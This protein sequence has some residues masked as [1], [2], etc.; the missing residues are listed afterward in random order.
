MDLSNHV[1]KINGLIV[2][3]NRD[4]ELELEVRFKDKIN[5]SKFTELLGK[6]KGMKSHLESVDPIITE[7]LDI[8]FPEKGMN[9]R[10]TLT[11]NK[12]IISFCKNGDFKGIEPQFIDK[13]RVGSWI[14]INDYNIRFNLKKEVVKSQKSPEVVAIKSQINNMNKEFRYKKRYSFVTKD[15]LFQFDLTVLKTSTTRE[16][17]GANVKKMKKEVKPFMEKFVIPP[18]HVNHFNTWFDALKDTDFVELMGEKRTNYI[19][20]KNIKSSNVFNNPMN[21]EV[22]IEYIGNKI[23]LKNTGLLEKF[24]ENIGYILQ[25][26]QGNYFIISASEKSDFYDSY[27]SLMKDSK[28]HAPQTVSLEMHNV[29]ERNYSDYYKT[30]NIR[31]GYSVTEKADGERNLLIVTKTGGCYMMNRKNVIKSLGCNIPNSKMTVL[32][33]EYITKTKDGKNICLFMVFDIYFYNGLDVRNKMLMRSVGEQ[34]S[35]ETNKSRLEYVSDFI[36]DLS[37]SHYYNIKLSIKK[38]TFLFGNSEVYDHSLDKEIDRYLENGDTETAK[39]LKSDVDIFQHSKTILDSSNFIYDTDGLIFTP[40]ELSVGEEPTIKKRNQYNGRWFRSFKWKPADQLTIDFL[41]TVKKDAQGKD[42]IKYIQSGSEVI[43]CKI[44]TMNVGYDPK[45]HTRY[46]SFKVMNEALVFSSEYKSIP[47]QPVNP[48]NTNSYL[49]YVPLDNGVIKCEN[50]TIVHD[51]DIVECLYNTNSGGHFN[52]WIPMRVRDVLTPNDFTTA[53]NVWKTIHYPVTLDMIKTGNIPK[54]QEEVYYYNI[55]NRRTL[56]S[57]SMAN[58]HSGVK[59]SIIKQYSPNG[60]KLLDLSCGKLGDMKHW[61]ETQLDMCVGM[62]LNRDNLENIDNG[63]CNRVLTEMVSN[64][65]PLIQNILLIWGDSSKNVRK[66][67]A[68]KDKLSKYYLD[69]I[70]GNIPI[71]DIENSKLRRFHGISSMNENT[72]FDIVSSQF[73]VHYYFENEVNLNGFLQNVSENLVKG[74]KF[75]GTCFNGRRVYDA[76][77]Y[78]NVI[79]YSEEGNP[80]W[81]IIKQFDSDTGFPN[82]STSLN[83]KIDVFF[84]SIGTTTTEYLVNMDYFIKKCAEFNLKILETNSFES[85][86]NELKASGGLYGGAETMT[87]GLREYSYMNDYFVFEKI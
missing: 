25:T 9:A 46:N 32:D 27:K 62:D 47:F 78:N 40:I 72:G 39:E 76:L 84:E 26:I 80:I 28:F 29:M 69:I 30:V 19:P 31:H 70:S 50:G 41:V 67:L 4:R 55:N 75:I 51:N 60:G 77:S 10:V 45:Q 3:S 56:S 7:T 63:A 71:G 34:R 23:D 1:D 43:P 44:L 6:L 87:V 49:V 74:G 59:K 64:K 86:Y 22:E 58:F 2:S 5:I 79:Q 83:M 18:K 13:I 21:F 38:K 20:K 73:S 42:I 14:D 54:T 53:N 33:G 85:K 52:K 48:Y 17:R 66:S 61:L 35:D 82:D 68:G 8:T 57:K 24:A 36:G 11:G 81:K 12:D 37:I 15:K 65:S 16:T